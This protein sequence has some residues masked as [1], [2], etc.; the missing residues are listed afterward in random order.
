MIKVP[1]EIVIPIYNEGVNVIKL[2]KQFENSIKSKFRV[3]LC[4][5]D[6]NDNIFDFKDDLKKFEFEVLL[7]KNPDKGPCA[8]IKNGLNYG[9]S[10]CV[11]V[12]PADDFLN[13]N[14]IDKLTT[15]K[16]NGTIGSQSALMWGQAAMLSETDIE[17]A[18]L[19]SQQSVVADPKNAKAWAIAAK[20]Y[21]LNKDLSSAERFI[22]KAKA[23]DPYLKE[24]QDL[25][26]LLVDEKLESLSVNEE[27]EE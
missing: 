19:L 3:L 20:I 16:N 8:A 11:I 23:I 10:D 27:K 24:I 14:I 4:Y 6:D 21:L 5:D 15:Y 9:N 13:T 12:Y 26:I 17:T 22:G 18:M 25:E 1:L 7:V 2:L